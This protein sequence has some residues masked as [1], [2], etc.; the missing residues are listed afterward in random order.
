[1][2]SSTVDENRNDVFKRVVVV[3]GFYSFSVNTNRENLL[4]REKMKKFNQ[5]V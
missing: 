3:D 2:Q 4:F 5:C 1:M